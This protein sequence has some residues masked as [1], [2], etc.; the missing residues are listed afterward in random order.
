MDGMVRKTNRFE[1]FGDSSLRLMK[2]ESLAMSLGSY[3]P[4][5]SSYL[6]PLLF[7]HLAK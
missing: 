5:L 4:S 7:C 2:F 1:D 3:L 6:I